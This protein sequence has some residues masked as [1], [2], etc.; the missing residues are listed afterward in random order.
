MRTLRARNVEE[1]RTRRGQRNMDFRFNRPPF[2]YPFPAPPVQK[3]ITIPPFLSK[4]FLLGTVFPSEV[5]SFNVAFQL[6][7]CL[8]KPRLYYN[9][10]FYNHHT[11]YSPIANPRSDLPSPIHTNPPPHSHLSISQHVHP[12]ANVPTHWRNAFRLYT[13]S[14]SPLPLTNSESEEM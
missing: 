1:H 2:P 10:R 8:K 12:T 7:S 13:H 9:A 14:S 5:S 6:I 4:L 3:A 11:R